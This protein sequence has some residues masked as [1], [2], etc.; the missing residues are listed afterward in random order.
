ML[1]GSDWLKAD[2][3]NLHRQYESDDV[4]SAVSWKKKKKNRHEENT[5][6]LWSRFSKDNH[7]K[8]IPSI[9]RSQI[10]TKSAWINYCGG[11]SKIKTSYLMSFS[12]KMGAGSHHVPGV[13]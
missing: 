3:W 12:E 10:K 11:G 9:I 2:K 7:T 4:E 8:Q 6:Q 13:T 5:R 1:T